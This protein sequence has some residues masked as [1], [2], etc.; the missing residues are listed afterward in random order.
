MDD[1][2]ATFRRGEGGETHQEAAPGAPVLTTQQGI[3]VSDDQNTLRA[4]AR[5]APRP[6]E[7]WARVV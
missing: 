7:P 3:P 2:N 1:P 5:R 6:G 4:G